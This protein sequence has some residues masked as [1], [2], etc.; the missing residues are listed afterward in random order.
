VA[1]RAASPRSTHPD[2]PNGVAHL[3]HAE[4]LRR[5]A[6]LTPVLGE[7]LPQTDALRRIPEAT[8]ADLL[9]AGLFTLA[10]PRAWGGAEL[11]PETWVR[12]SA[13]LAAGCASTS[14]VYGVLLGHMWLVSQFPAEAQAEVFG[15]RD[16]LVASLVRMGGGAPERVSGGFRWRAARGRFC[17]GIDHVAWVVA[18]GT[19]APNDNGGPEQRW[20]LI[21]R[22]EI[23]VVDDWFTVGLQGTGSKSIEIGDAFIPEH[24]TVLHSDVN[25]GRAPGRAVNTGPL[26]SLPGSTWAFPLPA[27][28]LGV[29][30]EAVRVLQRAFRARYADGTNDAAAALGSFGEAAT[31]IEIAYQVLLRRAKRL[32]DAAEQPYSAMDAIAHRRDIAFAVQ[33]ARRAVNSLMELSSG[34]GIYAASGI[35]RLWRDCNASAA[36]ASFGWDTAMSAFGRALLELPQTC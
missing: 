30:R 21:P 2:S 34:R 32:R 6:A 22:S 16:V 20:F 25:M 31:E 7:R 24:R 12:V 33:R 13:E 4:A 14:W 36:H 3:S 1:D 26:Y 11:W 29:A 19:I 35:E 15:D 18:G 10:T 8:I 5:A 17:S 9:R 28:C 27:T 23:T